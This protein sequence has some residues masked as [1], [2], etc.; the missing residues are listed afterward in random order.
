MLFST[1]W[2]VLLISSPSYSLLEH[3]FF[4]EI[5]KNRTWQGKKWGYIICISFLGERGFISLII[6]LFWGGGFVCLWSH[7][8]LECQVLTR[9]KVR[10][11]SRP[12]LI[13]Y[14]CVIR[15]LDDAF[16]FLAIS[17]SIRGLYKRR[18][19]RM[20]S[21]EKRFSRLPRTLLGQRSPKFSVS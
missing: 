7:K 12:P 9:F 20:L 6:F 17:R 13:C 3:R 5:F 10:D 1:F 21:T 11:F 15:A 14:A 18:Y 4:S 2:I 8:C 19:H 16:L